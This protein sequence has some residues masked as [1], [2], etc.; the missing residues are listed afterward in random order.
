MPRGRPKT[1]DENKLLDDAMAV[2]WREGARTVSLNGLA[3]AL[4]VSKPSLCSAFGT[5][6][7]LTA[8]A[9][10]RYARLEQPKAAAILQEAGP[11]GDVL[12]AY[13]QV[14]IDGMTASGRP[15]GC[16]LASTAAA[17]AGIADGPV[18]DALAAASAQARRPLIAFLTR[19]GVRDPEGL[20][21]FVLTQAAALSAAA[22]AGTDKAGL[23][24]L[25][26]YAIA[27]AAGVATRG[28]S[29]EDR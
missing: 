10:L 2:L 16:F 12:R 8:E 21:D 1:I 22:R 6:D 13:L 27:G 15:R 11:V 17:F 26:D 19:R 4:D 14:Y 18:P 24:R 28:V 20:S 29:Q 3:A 7:A 9:L 25:A 5:K 23:E